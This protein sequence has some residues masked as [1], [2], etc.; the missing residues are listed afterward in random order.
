MPAALKRM[1]S[2][3]VVQRTSDIG[4]RMALG[5]QRSNLL[6]LIVCDG[7]KLAAVGVAMGLAGA[8]ALT[9]VMLFLV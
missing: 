8:I 9:K 7:M 5:A 3:Y 1:L 2:Y 4:I 6:L